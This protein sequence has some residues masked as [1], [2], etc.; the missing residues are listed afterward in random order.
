[1]SW[2]FETEAL[3]VNIIGKCVDINLI[4]IYV[5]ISFD[6]VATRIY[7][8]QVSSFTL[9][10]IIKFKQDIILLFLYIF[11]FKWAAA[12]FF[13]FFV[14][15]KTTGTFLDKARGGSILYLSVFS[16]EDYRMLLILVC[17]NFH[18]TSLLWLILYKK[19]HKEQQKGPL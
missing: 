15:P 10:E 6:I 7:P 2:N 16:Y 3:S 14:P 19:R 9:I 8:Q 18:T 1:M 5:I 13:L 4:F 12:S 17:S 11:F